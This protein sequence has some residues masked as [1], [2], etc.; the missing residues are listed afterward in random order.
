MNAIIQDKFVIFKKKDADCL[1]YEDQVKL[2]ELCRYMAERANTVNHKYFVVNQDEPYAKII[3]KVII[4]G[5]NKKA[6]EHQITV[7]TRLVERFTN[8]PCVVQIRKP[9]HMVVRFE[10]GLSDIVPRQNFCKF[11]R[12]EQ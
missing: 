7:G 1:S 11:R 4:E 12:E 6:A 10:S 9:H 5:E 2:Q 3:E 8:L